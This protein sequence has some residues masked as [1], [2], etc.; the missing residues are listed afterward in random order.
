VATGAATRVA[1]G[2]ATAT[3]AIATAGAARSAPVSATWKRV[4]GRIVPL[5]HAKAN[6][7][8]RS[9]R[10]P[11]RAL[12]SLPPRQVSRARIAVRAAGVGAEADAADAVAEVGAGHGKVH[13]HRARSDRTVLRNTVAMPVPPGLRV[14]RGNREATARRRTRRPLPS[15]RARTLRVSCRPSRAS[16]PRRTSRCRWLTSSR[17][18]GPNQARSPTKPTSFGPRCRS[19]KTPAVAVPRSRSS[20]CRKARAAQAARA[21]RRR[22][23]MSPRAAASTRSSTSSKPL[24]PP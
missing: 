22:W 16:R 2:I 14:V 15:A 6:R 21:P 1:I 10:M 18:P 24:G 9:A 11:P 5:P 23:A 17:S 12:P 20:T 8:T 13:R 4:A 7:R 19:R 3:T